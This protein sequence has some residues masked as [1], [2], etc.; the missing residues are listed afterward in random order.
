M[1]PIVCHFYVFV[2]AYWI[3]GCLTSMILMIASVSVRMEHIYISHTDTH[4]ST[5]TLAAKSLNDFGNV[6][7]NVHKWIWYTHIQRVEKLWLSFWFCFVLSISLS[8][9]LFLFLVHTIPSSDDIFCSF[10]RLQKHIRH[11]TFFLFV[12]IVFV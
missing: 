4:L 8:L 9:D 5:Q 11:F 2:Y 6:K 10:F 1:F 7:I 3:A 12:L